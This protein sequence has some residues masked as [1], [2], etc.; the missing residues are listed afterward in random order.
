MTTVQSRSR[1][2]TVSYRYRGQTKVHTSSTLTHPE[3]AA[4]N[5]ATV[6][7]WSWATDVTL[8]EHL[9]IKTDRPIRVADLPG[10]GVPT[11]LPTC[12]LPAHEV[13]RYFRV[14]GYGPPALP[15]GD[16]VR[17]FLSWVADGRTR[18]DENGPTLGGDIRFPD[19]ATLQVRDVRIVIA[20]RH[21]DCTQLPH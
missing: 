21:I 1:F 2:W 6:T 3:A 7:G 18:H 8:T 4:R 10:P 20:T 16:R 11:P 5:W 15:T 17:R 19:P 12:P 14:Q 13:R 9:M